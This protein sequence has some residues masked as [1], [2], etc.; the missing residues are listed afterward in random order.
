VSRVVDDDEV[1]DRARE[2]AQELA[3]KPQEVLAMGRAAFRK[4]NDSDY[5]AAVARAVDNFCAA[6]ATDQAREGLSAFTEKRKPD[7]A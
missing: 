7:W 1:L 2:L 3:A 6:A 4:E 5:R